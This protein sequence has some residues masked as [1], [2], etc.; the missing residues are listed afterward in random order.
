MDNIK[1]ED[2]HDKVSTSEAETQDT[3]TQDESTQ[4]PL[5]TELERVQKKGEGKTEL[6]KALYTKKKLDERIR[7]LQGD[8]SAEVETADEDAPVT[9]GML[10]KMQ[11]DTAV[12][13]ALNLA[14]E[15]QSEAERELTK[16]H[17]VNTIKST[18]NPSEDL[19]MA[20][21]IVNAKKN[22]KIVEEL[23]RKGTAKTHSSASGANA[24]YTDETVELT[25]TEQLFMKKFG[26]SKEEILKARSSEK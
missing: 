4:D 23:S 24:N 2:L 7:E 14:D 5:K 21:A 20:R 12:K 6:E 17:I 26:L 10:K 25:S 22:S 15:I 9:I 8:S 16:Y 13:T 3:S 18:G 1:M 11:Q 19:A